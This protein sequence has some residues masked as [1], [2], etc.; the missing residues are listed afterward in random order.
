M[1]QNDG[2]RWLFD[3]WNYLDIEDFRDGVM[4]TYGVEPSEL[5][6]DE[7]WRYLAIVE[8]QD[9]EDEKQNI[10]SVIGDEKIIAYG[11]AG[12]WNG[13][14]EGG[15][16]AD[17]LQDAIDKIRGNDYGDIGFY[18]DD[19]NE[20]HMTFSHHDGTHD[21]ILHAITDA[22]YD[23]IDEMEYELAEQDIERDVFRTP[24]YSMKIDMLAV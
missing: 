21:L 22:G 10:Q 16:I 1:P 4:A 23:Y 18:V 9:Y 11:T 15:F 12:V 20:L 17:N 19:D 8:E 14:F 13:S 2:K 24:E 3:H 6:E 5:D 7:A